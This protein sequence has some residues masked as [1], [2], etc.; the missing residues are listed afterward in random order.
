MS[1]GFEI[2]RPACKKQTAA[3]YA[4]IDPVKEWWHGQ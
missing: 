2:A 4:L 1:A 3:T